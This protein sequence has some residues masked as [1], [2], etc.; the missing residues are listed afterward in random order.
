MLWQAVNNL[1]ASATVLNRGSN[2]LQPPK[3]IPKVDNPSELPT[4]KLEPLAKPAKTQ[5][6]SVLPSDFFDK[7]E[8]EHQKTGKA[9]SLNYVFLPLDLHS[10]SSLSFFFFK[11]NF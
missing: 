10:P 1:K 9:L 8:A 7:T 4:A 5:P 11:W 6:S 3:D 2:V